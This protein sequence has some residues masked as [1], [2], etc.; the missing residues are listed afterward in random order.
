M[1]TIEATKA[2][3]QTIHDEDLFE[4]IE[5]GEENGVPYV[6]VKVRFTPSGENTEAILDEAVAKIQRQL[7]AGITLKGD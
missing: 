6:D 5:T 2:F 4:I 7:L 3:V 1:K